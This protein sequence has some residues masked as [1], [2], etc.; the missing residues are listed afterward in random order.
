MDK[1]IQGSIDYLAALSKTK[2]A[3]SSSAY[4]TAR[5]NQVDNLKRQMGKLKEV[6]IA[7]GTSALALLGAESCPFDA[8][9][10][11]QLEQVV[12]S[13]VSSDIVDA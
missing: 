1:I 4:N 10:I 13:K 11:A 3:K 9:E 7:E 8:D 5:K 12:Q 6:D 2:S